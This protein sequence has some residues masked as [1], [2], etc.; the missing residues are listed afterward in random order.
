MTVDIET[1]G[2]L[3]H[4]PLPA[5]T[6]ACL[7]DGETRHELLLYGVSDVERSANVARLLVSPQLGCSSPFGLA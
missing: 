7:Y 6:C 2:L 5:I 3:H 1:L 4:K